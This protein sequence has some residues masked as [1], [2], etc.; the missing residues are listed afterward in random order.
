MGKFYLIDAEK[1]SPG[2][3]HIFGNT[4]KDVSIG[5]K[6]GSFFYRHACDGAL[7]MWVNPPKV[8]RKYLD[9]ADEN[10]DLK[11]I[12]FRAY[13]PAE[14]GES[15]EIPDPSRS[16]ACT[17]H[18]PSMLEVQLEKRVRDLEQRLEQYTKDVGTTISDIYRRI[19]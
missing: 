18:Y 19:P 1:A 13:D 3:W 12:E 15:E 17:W 5:V 4:G 9:A 11:A 10:E 8:C 2:E 14:N 6:V 7:A 16:S